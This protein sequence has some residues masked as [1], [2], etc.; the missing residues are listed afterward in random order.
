MVVWWRRCGGGGVGGGGVGGGVGGGGGGGVGGGGV[1]AVWIVEERGDGT[2]ARGLTG[3]GDGG[4]E[5]PPGANWEVAL[6][7]VLMFL[8]FQRFRFIVCCCCCCCC[9]LIKLVSPFGQ[10]KHNFKAAQS[11]I[12]FVISGRNCFLARNVRK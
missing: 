7:V 4:G 10:V 6:S 1:V 12:L 9:V 2:V 11:C 5:L 8:L 3:S